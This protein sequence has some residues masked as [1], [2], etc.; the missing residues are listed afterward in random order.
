MQAR[1]ASTARCCRRAVNWRIKARRL[2]VDS[3]ST[4]PRGRWPP[5]WRSHPACS[6]CATGGQRQPDVRRGHRRGECQSHRE[7]AARFDL[8][9][10]EAMLA[11]YPLDS[12]APDDRPYRGLARLYA[13]AGQTQQARKYLTLSQKLQSRWWN[14]PDGIARF[15]EGQVLE[16]EGHLPRRWRPTRIVCDF[17]PST[18]TAGSAGISTLAECLTG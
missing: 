13:A 18:R 15:T 12:M 5:P 8:S 3:S 2:S 16:A 14:P 6:S 7:A 4:R 10:V 1:T 11:Q 17:L 9:A